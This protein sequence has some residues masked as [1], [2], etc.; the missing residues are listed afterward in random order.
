MSYMRR[1][2]TAYSKRNPMI[3]YC[4]GMNFILGRMLKY[5][6]HEEDAFWVFTGLVEGILPIDYYTQLVGVQV[7]VRVFQDLIAD[8]LKPISDK[9]KS[10]LCDTMFFSLNWFICLYTDKLP[11]HISVPILDIIMIKGNEVLHN[12]GLAIL[13]IIREQILGCETFRKSLPH[14]IILIFF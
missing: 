14:R 3:G 12:I 10:L 13:H 1:V 9:F 2:L 5:L 6:Q 4:Q 11:E 7:D 8:R